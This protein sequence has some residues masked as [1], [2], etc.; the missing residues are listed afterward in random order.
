M[1]T[2]D[3]AA[4][5]LSESLRKKAEQIE[6]EKKLQE[7]SFHGLSKAKLE[8]LRAEKAAAAAQQQQQQQQQKQKLKIFNEENDAA[9]TK[10][11]SIEVEPKQQNVV[12]QT[13]SRPSSSGNSRPGSSKSERSARVPLHQEDKIKFSSSQQ[14]YKEGDMVPIFNNSKTVNNSHSFPLPTP[15]RKN[16][17]DQKSSSEIQKKPSSA[18]TKVQTARTL[19]S[20][21]LE[22]KGA[23][24]FLSSTPFSARINN[25]LLLQHEN[26]DVSPSALDFQKRQQEAKIIKQGEQMMMISNSAPIVVTNNNNN[27]GS[28]PCFSFPAVA[29]P[30]KPKSLPGGG[31]KGSLMKGNTVA[32]IRREM[33]S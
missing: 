23:K 27:G 13:T 33:Q 29:I 16:S 32:R 3:S 19:P 21:P 2:K 10:A 18:T 12:L 4:R 26:D 14:Q 6:M 8:K 25:L 15:P 11:E 9:F 24:R 28:A 30:Q 20:K 17:P 5:D 22:A 7:S 31:G 1:D